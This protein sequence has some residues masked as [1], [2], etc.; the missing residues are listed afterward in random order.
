MR[1]GKEC[2]D[3]E[4]TKGVQFALVCLQQQLQLE[5]QAQPLSGPLA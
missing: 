2:R 4:E 1:T 3:E 5:Q